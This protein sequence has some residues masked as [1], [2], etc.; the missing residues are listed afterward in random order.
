MTHVFKPHTV[1]LALG[2]NL[3]D[4][5]RNLDQACSLLME[6][7]VD[8]EQ[9]S[10]WHET[11]PVGGPEGQGLFLNGVV[12]ATT[13]L[14]PE[15]LLDV[16]HTIERQLGRVRTV[17]TGPRTI[18]VDILLF[19]DIKLDSQRLRIPH[20]RMCERDFVMNP[21]AEINPQLTLRLRQS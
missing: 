16:I 15:D 9:R 12:L 5:Q 18:D 21:L 13:D 4:R 10:S 2:S 7:G 17:L 3:G 19:D 20:P 6:A 8:I 11:E 1:Y 14:T